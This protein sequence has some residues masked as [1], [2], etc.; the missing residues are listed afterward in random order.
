[1]VNPASDARGSHV[2]NPYIKLSIF[3][4]SKMI[5]MLMLGLIEGG[6]SKFQNPNSKILAITN[7]LT[8]V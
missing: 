6:N 5:K 4:Q 8:K 3:S 1:M 7:L 2:A